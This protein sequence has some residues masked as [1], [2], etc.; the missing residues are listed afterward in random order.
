MNIATLIG[1]TVFA[2]DAG[3]ELGS[4]DRLL[5]SQEERRLVG[6][7]VTPPTGATDDPERKQVL[8]VEKVHSFGHDA[9]TIA[10]EADLDVSRGGALPEGTVAVGQAPMGTV[11]TESGEAFGEVTLLEASE[12][13]YQLTRMDVG[14]GVFSSS[15]LVNIRDVVSFGEDA[16]V[17]RD[18]VLGAGGS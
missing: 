14:Q 2:L 15:I 3:K 10:S 8:A 17:V 12:P 9:V 5:I 18:S 6:F 13:E 11:T 16:I 7:V 1:M 4:I